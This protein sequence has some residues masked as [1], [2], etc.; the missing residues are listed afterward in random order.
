M[1]AAAT[2]AYFS[3]LHRHLTTMQAS[4]ATGEVVPLDTAVHWMIEAA[5]NAHASGNK[6]MFIGNGGSAGIC[7]HMAADYSKNGGLR[8]TAFNDASFLTCLSNDL[9]Y[10]HVFAKQIELHARAGDL[11][12][13]ISSSGRST[14]IL[15]GVLAARAVG[16]G[17]V[18]LSGFT[19]DN[20][21]RGVGDMNFYVESG[22]YGFVEMSHL[23]LCH[24][25]LDISMGWSAE[26]P[27]A[28][29]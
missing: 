21:L 29:E 17:V 3:A 15:N 12:V 14:N 9:G 19:P 25:I 23:G 10:D 4:N 8:A 22:E 1:S 20:P 26:A 6:L 18:T 13:A 5:R 2:E 11:L 16:C 7:S 24:C 28:A 27:H